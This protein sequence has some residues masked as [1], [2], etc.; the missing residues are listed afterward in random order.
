MEKRFTNVMSKVPQAVVVVTTAHYDEDANSS[1]K[2]GMT[3]SSF[4]SCSLKPPIVSFSVRADSRMHGLLQVTKKFAINVLSA[5]QVSLGF[6]FS[7]PA[8]DGVDQFSNIPH[9]HSD[10]NIPILRNACSVLKCTAHSVALIGDH[11]IWYGQVNYAHS[12]GLDMDPLLYYSRTYR[13]ISDVT[14]MQAFEDTSLPFEDWTH[15]AHLRMAY[16]YIMEYG[17]EEAAAHIKRGIRKYNEQHKEKVKVGYHETITM[18]YVRQ[19]AKAIQDYAVK[20]ATFEDFIADSSN[21]FLTER[22]LLYEY[23]SDERINSKE[24][25]Q[26]YILPDKKQLPVLQQ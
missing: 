4:T 19:V 5:N 3:C 15:Q 23:Y 25:A 10:D 22:H 14:F 17:W 20:D 26:T 13:T 18:F 1:L 11:N 24:A 9:E 7:K 21:Q 12:N 6:H 8:V 16:N 2:R